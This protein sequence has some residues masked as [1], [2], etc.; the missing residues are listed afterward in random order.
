LD[1]HT[2]KN[3]KIVDLDI[4]GFI[5]IELELRRMGEENRHLS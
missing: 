4:A 3:A 2:I 1:S 5:Q